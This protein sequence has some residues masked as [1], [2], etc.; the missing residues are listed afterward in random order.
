VEIQ[1]KVFELQQVILAA[2]QDALTANEA[3]ATLLKRIR[4]L[5]KEVASLKTWQAE[6]TLR[7]QRG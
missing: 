3:Q 2:Q 5:E 4:E 1:G 6:G 7:T